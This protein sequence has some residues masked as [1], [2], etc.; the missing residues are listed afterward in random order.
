MI[1]VRP[2]RKNNRGFSLVEVMISIVLL[3]FIGASAVLM[4]HHLARGLVGIGQGSKS[5]QTLRDV[6]EQLRLQ[7]STNFHNMTRTRQ[8]ETPVDAPVLVY[9]TIQPIDAIKGTRRVLLE[10][11]W[12][13][14]GEKKF[15]Q[16]TFDLARVSGRGGGTVRARFIDAYQKVNHSIEHGVSGIKI[17]GKKSDGSD[18][19]AVSGGDGSVILSGLETDVSGNP[20]YVTVSGESVRYYF[21]HADDITLGPPA[22][23]SGFEKE[24]STIKLLRDGDVEDFGT[25]ELWP[26]AEV[27][28]QVML[29]D[30][31]DPFGPRSPAMDAEVRLIPNALPAGSFHNCEV[32]VLGYCPGDAQLKT[33][34][35]SDGTFV[36][37][38]VV[39]GNYRIYMVGQPSLYKVGRQGKYAAVV[40]SGDGLASAPSVRLLP[41]DVV[42]DDYY[43]AGDPL[44]PNLQNGT[45]FETMWIGDIQGTIKIQPPG[46]GPPQ[47]ASSYMDT[48]ALPGKP[49]V[50]PRYTVYRENNYT[51][52]EISPNSFGGQTNF[53]DTYAWT[54]VYEPSQNSMPDPSVITGD[55]ENGVQY[56]W[57]LIAPIL[58][59]GDPAKPLHTQAGSVY[60]RLSRTREPF[61]PI[62]KHPDGDYMYTYY[63][64]SA[65]DDGGGTVSKFQRFLKAGTTVTFDLVLLQNDPQNLA[66]MK[67]NI[68]DS[69]GSTVLTGKIGWVRA[70]PGLIRYGW[71]SSIDKTPLEC[72]FYPNSW[73][74]TR[75]DGS[76]SMRLNKN[77]EDTANFNW[78]TFCDPASPTCTNRLVPN[79]PGRSTTLDFTWEGSAVNVTVPFEGDFIAYDKVADGSDP[80]TSPDIVAINLTGLTFDITSSQPSWTQTVS[81]GLNGHVSF[82]NQVKTTP[83]KRGSTSAHLDPGSNVT[84]NITIADETGW[85][86]TALKIPANTSS[87]YPL[88]WWDVYNGVNYGND[89]VPA[90]KYWPTNTCTAGPD[91]PNGRR[92]FLLRPIAKTGVIYGKLRDGKGNPVSATVRLRR[93]NEKA[94]YTPIDYATQADVVAAGDC[95]SSECPGPEI[96]NYVFKDVAFLPTDGVNLFIDVVIGSN[97]KTFYSI[98][99][100]N[101][102][103]GVYNIN[104]PITWTETPDNP[105]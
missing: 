29:V 19:Q 33:Y 100:F 102:I 7:T 32:E 51:Y 36:F 101:G 103:S 6:S 1:Y 45:F 22:G 57:R 99:A 77:D 84:Q 75:A 47:F 50:I 18:I 86:H 27:R 104:L 69:D 44:N 72:R 39:P 3:A 87:T 11:E 98:E 21:R 40:H 105:L 9:S 17:S 8:L 80:D 26:P 93:T 95:L 13:E 49:L 42:A 65:Y 35:A 48:S 23:K 55:C 83:Q 63:T 71:A 2:K 61:L 30:P 16:L 67:G 85:Y 79:S 37:S 46:G 5:M 90:T 14:A 60:F 64:G 88:G 73:I 81:V 25:V 91:C 10:A 58:L 43:S 56:P 52:Y 70:N 24:F 38:R 89:A 31:T 66:N 82:S 92:P 4:I 62:L 78:T 96:Y 68:I 20:I 94:P 41:R 15:K 76:Y 74:Y 34:A 97:S 28:G 59:N 53:S 12:T 54:K